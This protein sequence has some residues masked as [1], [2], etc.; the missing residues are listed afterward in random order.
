MLLPSFFSCAYSGPKRYGWT[1]ER[2]V[3][4]HDGISLHQLLSQEFSIIFDKNIDLCDLPC[5]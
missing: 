1:G 2:W 4:S 5:S 3:Y